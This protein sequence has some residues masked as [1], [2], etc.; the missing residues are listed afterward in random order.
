MNYELFDKKYVYFD[1]NDVSKLKGK[2]GFGSDTF[3]DLI[4]KVNEDARTNSWFPC[5]YSDDTSRP[6]HLGTGENVRF[7]YYDPF[8]EMKLA[9]K[10]GE[11]LQYAYKNWRNNAFYEETWYDYEKN[12]MPY[13]DDSDA[14]FNWRVKPTE[15][16]WYV[17]FAENSFL[18]VSLITNLSNTVFFSGTYEECGKW[19]NE[20]DS[21]SSVVSAFLRGDTIQWKPKNIINEWQDW[22]SS[23]F[24]TVNTMD[25]NYWRIKLEYDFDDI[26]DYSN[27]QPTEPIY[28]LSV[29][30]NGYGYLEF[31]ISQDIKD[32]AIYNGSKK[33]CERMM[34]IIGNEFEEEDISHRDISYRLRCIINKYSH[35]KYKRRM[36]NKE[37]AEWLAKGNG[38]V[39]HNGVYSITIDHF[40]NYF[41]SD[42]NKEVD[43]CLIRKWDSD[44]W[45][46]PLIEV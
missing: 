19:I 17:I 22:K 27:Y 30:K 25:E 5:K 40:H 46:E 21:L 16:I 14:R 44:K 26:V 7:F 43:D 23:E 20:H 33:E 35:E 41:K 2:Y 29:N 34:K 4:W 11:K 37:L 24:P 32:G 1:F 28:Y 38:E 9:F 42:E 39:K 3:N 36:T 15:E 6:F 10:K 31:T 13:F 45:E 12:T 8:Y 18:R